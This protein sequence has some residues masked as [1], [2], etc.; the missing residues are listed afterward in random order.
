MGLSTQGCNRALGCAG[1]LL[2]VAMMAGC[3][4]ERPESVPADAR[5]VARQSGSQPV[6]FT[7]PSDGT[8]FVYDRSAQKM[9]YS[10]RLKH[11]ETLELDPRRNGVRVDGRQVVEAKLR[12]L[13]EY[14]VWFDA[15][16]QSTP[17]GSSTAG[18]RITVK[19]G[20]AE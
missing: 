12:D 17:S 15:E 18:S 4:P 14:Q 3:A 10:G 16:P 13:N 2:L 11:G 8:A 1:A 9:V 6:N 5:S 20:G 19:T 7:A